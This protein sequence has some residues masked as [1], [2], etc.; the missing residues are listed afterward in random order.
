MRATQVA[1]A[2]GCILLI[3]L[4]PVAIFEPFQQEKTT[5]RGIDME[6]FISYLPEEGYI[7]IYREE[8]YPDHYGYIIYQNCT[9][10]QWINKSGFYDYY[11]EISTDYIDGKPII[12]RDLPVMQTVTFTNMTDIDIYRENGTLYDILWYPESRQW[13]NQ[14]IH[15]NGMALVKPS[16]NKSIQIEEKSGVNITFEIETVGETIEKND[17]VTGTIEVVDFHAVNDPMEIT[18][19]EG[20]GLLASMIIGGLVG[21]YIVSRGKGKP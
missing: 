21:A 17:T 14:T 12:V 11:W 4:V 20:Y 15:Y 9:R 10:Q 13:G 5:D 18:D 1:I 3:L 7:E 16:I 6:Q 19:T 8:I 2:V